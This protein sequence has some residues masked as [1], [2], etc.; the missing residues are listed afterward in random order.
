MS[1]SILWSSKKQGKF[2]LKK[3]NNQKSKKLKGEMKN[4][5]YKGCVKGHTN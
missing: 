4:Q 5:L 1:T 3:I 2:V